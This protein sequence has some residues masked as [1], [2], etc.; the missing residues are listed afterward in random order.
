MKRMFIVL[1]ILVVVSGC[2]SVPMAP[3]SEDT[4]AKKFEPTQGKSSVYLYRNENF[5]AA[6]KV[7]VSAN[8]K[9]LGQTA[10]FTYYLLQL[11]PGL[12]KFTCFAENTESIT[13]NT[14]PDQIYFVRQEMKMGL[15]AARCAVYE[16]S[17][18]EGKA[19]ILESNM[20]QIN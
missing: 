4:Q 16:T 8:D 5:G 10:P 7:T 15:W 13:L 1:L 12:H 17:A 2:A 11:E 3:L 14:K 6:I 18:E 20:A 19:G 9:M